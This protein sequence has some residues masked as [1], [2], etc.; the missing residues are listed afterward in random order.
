VSSKRTLVSVCFLCLIAS[1]VWI[2]AAT[3]AGSPAEATRLWTGPTEIMWLPQGNFQAF[4]LRISTPG[5][6]ILE[7]AFANGNCPYI[8]LGEEDAAIFTDGVYGF[9]LLSLPAGLN[10]RHRTDVSGADRSEPPASASGAI[11]QYGTFA[12]HQGGILDDTEPEIPLNQPLDV[13]HPDDVIIQGSLCV[14]FDCVNN[15]NF[16]FDTIILKENNLQIYFEDTSVGTFPTNDW[17]IVINSHDNGGPSFFAIEDSTAG[18]IPFLIE[19]GAAA[20]SIYVDDY[21]RVGLGTSVPAV[22]LHTRNSDTP[23]VRLEQDSSS[24]YSAQTWDVAGNEANFFVRDVTNGSRL[25]FRIQP[26]TPTNTLT[27]RADGKVG[28]G[29]W[30]PTGNLEV[31]TTGSNPLFLLNRT[32]GSQAFI[33]AKQSGVAFGSYNNYPVVVSVNGEKTMMLYQDGSLGLINGANCT[34]AGVW[35]DASRRAYKTDIR[36]LTAEEARTT[37]DNLNPVQ[38]TPKAEPDERYLGFIA[39]DVPELVADGNRRG[40]SPMDIVAVLTRVVQDQQKTIVDLQRR[41][42]ELERQSK[43]SAR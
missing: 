16:G 27:L 4:V 40:V 14:G 3:G 11:L 41:L 13:V 1:I 35:L 10:L 38:Y 30:G 19:A 12:I 37:L 24:G 25:P 23:A 34:S 17:R 22:K 32:D 29:T 39:E 15:E 21:G 2:P 43:K 28:I 31:A 8:D 7:R 42:A 18:R 20:N 26:G 33:L 9:E 36:N 5:G 6:Q